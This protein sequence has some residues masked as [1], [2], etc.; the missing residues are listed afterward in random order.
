MAEGNKLEFLADDEVEGY[1]KPAGNLTEW[2][3]EPSVSTLKEDFASAKNNQGAMI[4]KI[5]DWL[6]AMNIQGKYKPKTGKNRSEVQPRLV[7]KQAEWRYS[8]L[9]ESFLS[10]EKLF[11]VE[12]ATFEDHDGAIQNEL[13][14]NHQFR[15]VINP[16]KFIDEYVRTTVNEGTCFVKVGWLRQ[17]E[18]IT[19]DEPLYNYSHLNPEDEEQM[20]MLEEAIAL[21]DSNIRGFNELDPAIVASVLQTQQSGTPMWA[22]ATGE[23]QEV[24]EE[25]IIENKPVLE[26]IDYRN[27]FIDPSCDGDISKAKFCVIS[28]ETSYADLL[29]DGRY[30]N[31]DKISYS[32][33]GILNHPDHETNT[34]NT[35]NFKDKARKIVVAY[36]YWGF[37]DIEDNG[38]LEPIVATWIGNQMIR[39]E[40]NPFPDQ[41]IPIVA[42][43]YMPLKKSVHG[44]TDAELLTD[45]QSILGGIT[46]GMIDSL[47]RTASG[48]RGIPKDLLDVTNQRKYE[49]GEDYFYNPRQG[50]PRNAIID[51]KFGEL[52]ASAMTMLSLQHQEAESLTGVKSFTGGLSGDTYG[53]VVAGIQGM[54]DASSKREMAILRRMAQGMKEIGN[55]VIAMNAVF[56]NEE[57]V[58]RVTNERYVVIRREDLKGNYDL[59]VDISTTE[60]DEAKAQDLGFMLQTIGNNMDL[61]MRNLVLSEIA[62]LKRMPKLANE[63]K[64]YAPQPDPA[65]EKAKELE[66]IKMELENKK[67][68]LELRQIESIVM[69]NEA[70]ARQLGADADISDLDF[71]EQ[72]TGTKHARELE[73]ASE[74]ARGNVN[75]ELT[76]ALLKTKKPD[77][78]DGDFNAALG[79]S[80][81]TQ[82]EATR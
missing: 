1:T 22:E 16:V 64:N 82:P 34:P 23:V 73:K 66:L 31:L 38:V 79:F 62:R 9:T 81:L 72:E 42:V 13:L 24:E 51:H 80:L 14:I 17:T 4:Q 18:I 69:V 20:A 19:V 32:D 53:R 74:Q 52:P 47:A 39:M 29:K 26:F 7:R 68:E 10:S 75:L 11:N 25:N 77:E 21:Q 27:I 59:I 54:M 5:G 28:Y 8:A 76:K 46:R 2:K 70:K 60:V 30:T 37:Y 44:E 48:Q 56:L 40:R 6:D 15:T 65:A 63:I 55:K 41:S 71:V 58:V 57:E 61:D 35:F 12:P 50:D 3:N 67:L 45:N 49:N 43:P 78:V 36:E 33:S